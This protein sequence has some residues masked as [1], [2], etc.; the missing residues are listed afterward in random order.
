MPA[1]G[2]AAA[3]RKSGGIK[4]GAKSDARNSVTRVDALKEKVHSLPELGSTAFGPALYL[5]V[6]IASQVPGSSVFI[7]TDGGANAGLGQL[8]ATPGHYAAGLLGPAF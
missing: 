1:C 2:I 8:E 4:Q 3:P 6:A 5:S 7:C